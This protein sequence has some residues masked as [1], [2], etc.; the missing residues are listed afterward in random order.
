MAPSLFVISVMQFSAER[1]AVL[2]DVCVA[3]KNKKINMNFLFPNPQTVG[4]PYTE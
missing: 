2:M 1:K 4:V 3:Y